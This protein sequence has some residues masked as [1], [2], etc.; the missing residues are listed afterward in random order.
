MYIIVLER[1]DIMS[2]IKGTV[3][4]I[5]EFS[6]F[7][8]PGIRTTVFLKGCPLRCS[9]CHNP[10]GQSFEREI[11]RSPNGCIGCGKCRRK[12]LELTG[13]ESLVTECIAVCPQNLIRE[14]GTVYTPKMLCEKLLKNRIFFRSGGGVTFSGGEPLSQAEFVKACF[15]KLKGK[16]NRC[17]QTSGFCSEKH[18]REVLAESDYVLFDLKVLNPERSQK[19]TGADI[20]IILKN[21]DILVKSGVAF[22]VRLPLIPGITDTKEN[23]KDIISLLNKYG[24]NY[25]EALPYNKNAGAKYRL[26]G[27]VYTPQFDAEK[28]VYIPAEEYLNSGIMLKVL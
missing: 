28:E 23:T 6:T 13:K 3:F 2:D 19:Y 25:A 27:R 4:A 1:A 20:G 5:E 15:V 22:T 14:A 16:I 8:G 18:F 21:F 11:L 24:I 26:A 10:E 9:W 17:I 7:D 12:A